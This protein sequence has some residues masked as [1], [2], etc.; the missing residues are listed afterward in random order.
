MMTKAKEAPEKQSQTSASEKGEG[1]DPASEAAGPAS[2]TAGGSIRPRGPARYEVHKEL[3]KRQPTEAE[4]EARALERERADARARKEAAAAVTAKQ[5]AADEARARA[6]SAQPPSSAK[7]SKAGAYKSDDSRYAERE[8]ARAK[9]AAQFEKTLAKQYAKEITKE[10]EKSISDLTKAREE[11]DKSR[12]HLAV[13]R[14]SNLETKEEMREGKARDD[15]ARQRLRASTLLNS[16]SAG[17]KRKNGEAITP[18]E[19]QNAAKRSKLKESHAKLLKNM[20]TERAKLD[21]EAERHVTDARNESNSC[22]MNRVKPNEGKG[23]GWDTKA[24]AK[25]KGKCGLILAVNSAEASRF[26]ADLD[27]KAAIASG[28]LEQLR[29]VAFDDDEDGPLR[30]DEV[31]ALHRLET[32]DKLKREVDTITEGACK[33]AEEQLE[34]TDRVLQNK[35]SKAVE[36]KIRA[37]DAAKKKA[38]ERIACMETKWKLLRS[39]LVTDETEEEKKHRKRGAGKKDWDALRDPGTTDDE[40]DKDWCAL[41]RLLDK[42]DQEAKKNRRSFE[43]KTNRLEAE[44]ETLRGGMESLKETKEFAAAVQ[45][46]KKWKSLKLKC[47][48]SRT[49]LAEKTLTAGKMRSY[50]EKSVMGGVLRELI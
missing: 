38:R 46:A 6:A 41:G 36:P 43:D 19:T 13:L 50:V 14:A 2:S 27:E 10:Q 33:A 11:R 39:L 3:D 4:A 25:P 26:K 29:K 37:L 7:P 34:K 16:G 30:E 49:Q 1:T 21:V 42:E 24:K 31:E 35:C 40:R 45:E 28:R 47:V 9:T 18:E 17:R 20:G 15:E 22:L 5:K 23:G 48:V 44:E 8:H 12:S 32:R